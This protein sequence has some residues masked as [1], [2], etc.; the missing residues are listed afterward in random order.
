MP[1]KA[2]KTKSSKRKTRY[3][4]TP[5]L[6]NTRK[7]AGISVEEW[8][9]TLR[10]Q[11][12]GKTK[13]KISNTGEGL[14]FSDYTVHNPVTKNSYKVALR[15][16]GH[17]LNYCSC[18]D[19][20]TNQLGTCKHIEALLTYLR[21]KT[22]TRK[23]LKQ[24]YTT[25]YSSMYVEYRGERKVKL[26]IGTDDT[27]AY[28][29]LF[30][31]YVQED[32]SLNE[33][34]F[35]EIDQILRKAYKINASFRCYED[36]LQLIIEHREE[37]QRKQFFKPFQ[38]GKKLPATKTLKAKLF[39]Y[40]IEGVLFCLLAGK[41]I[42]ADDMGLGKT[43]QAIATA[44]VMHE[45]LQVQKVVIVCPTS[46]KYQWQSEIKKF[47]NSSVT[48][49][50]GNYLMRRNL[51]ET[52]ESLY[53]IVSYNVAVNDWDVINAM[54]PGFIILD[55]A[56]RIKNWQTKISQTIKKL[57]S[58]YA[59]ILTGTP[60]EN[61]L[62]ELYSLTQFINP[63]LL[64][65]LY[66]FTSAHETYDE[67][68]KV[69]GYKNL[70]EISTKLEPILLRRTKKQV[71]QQLP[72]R[73]DKNLFVTI[74]PEQRRLHTEY[75]DTVSKLVQKWRKIGFLKE[76]DRQRLLIFLNLMRMV[77]NSTYIVDQKTNYQ[78][79][80]DE[81]FSMLQQILEMPGE[82]IVIFS[83]WERFT[84]LIAFELDRLKIGYANLN[85]HIPSQK[86]KDLFDRF[87]NEPNCRIFLST[88]AGGVGLNLQAASYLINMDLPWNP[89]VLEQRIARIYR[90]GQ[91]KN[92]NII[93]FI[94]ESTIEQEMLGKLK[95]KTALAAGILDNGEPNI[96]LAD[97]KFNSFM[98]SVED[99]VNTAET[100][101]KHDEPAETAK[102]ASTVEQ[103]EL[104]FD[105]D[106]IKEAVE[107]SN[108]AIEQKPASNEI[109]GNLLQ[110]ASSFIN[111]LGHVLS[112]TEATEQ[113][114]QQLTYKNEKTGQTYLQIPV[115]N[116]GIIKNVVAVLA[117]LFGLSKKK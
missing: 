115:N 5:Q 59:L 49:I 71:L 105:D 10:K 11:I 103:T 63:L 61:K 99:L 17:E 47:T 34:A 58:K 65:S 74:T 76:E 38:K 107:K 9:S 78:T 94:A 72:E 85:G 102:P 97:S 37:Q 36:A 81:L 56:Q 90:Y 35:I 2:F 86:R 91:K 48:V 69:I 117:G 13:F 23:A 57:K 113:F 26:R 110:S 27:T 84:R 95:F 88:D 92:V 79:K 1:T 75:Q 70:N 77:C 28:Q 116:E 15:S 4:S 60:L 114:I 66:N 19:F 54:Q 16:A 32:G 18:Y 51:Y 53:K 100:A 68:G 7:P 43:I 96:F 8:Q 98:Q 109:A 12:A 112:S 22:N 40:Q 25:G 21:K 41:S 104:L 101:T 24:P 55:E 89:A 83:Q 82:K 46:L 80:L 106:D 73:M 93:N 29:K 45:H 6:S 50:E 44:Q 42:L 87:N 33:K 52:D 31:Q 111:Q 108:G 20:K 62:T 30:K 64:G 14:A 39:P 67:N 3:K